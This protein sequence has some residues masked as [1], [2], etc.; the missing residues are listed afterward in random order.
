MKAKVVN[1][2]EGLASIIGTF[3]GISDAANDDEF[4]ND[5]LMKAHNKSLDKFNAIA[6]AKS[7][8]TKNLNR[9]FNHMY[10]FGVA[11]ITPGQTIIAD[12]TSQ[13]AR[14]WVFKSVSS[15]RVINTF[16]TFRDAVVPNPKPSQRPDL[17]GVSRDI[18]SRM[19]TRKYVFRRRAEMVEYGKDVHISPYRAKALIFP[20]KENESGVGFWPRSA[21]KMLVSL[22]GQT[23]AG[24]SR[25][26]MAFTN[27]FLAWWK[28]Q[29]ELEITTS[30]HN[31]FA[32]RIGHAR[33]AADKKAQMK[34]P[35]ATNV[36]ATS[37]KAAA[38]AKKNMKRGVRGE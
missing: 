31:S 18:V 16:V 8:R 27:Y 24:R 26:K 38:K 37:A 11:G 6:A 33:R 32:A 29:G 28:T 5:I 10:E 17:K 21:G 36:K 22:D 23:G 35:S 13:A 34:P 30:A 20:S 19:S 3:Q 1:N 25:H 15:G 12:P 7:A 4:I 14:L 9:N 2:L